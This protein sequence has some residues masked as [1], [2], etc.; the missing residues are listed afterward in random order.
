MY[1]KCHSKCIQC[2]S[3]DFAPRLPNGSLGPRLPNGSL[4]AKSHLI[5]KSKESDNLN[6]AK[7]LLS[8]TVVL[9]LDN[10]IQPYM[11]TTQTQISASHVSDENDSDAEDDS[12][13][14][15]SIC[16]TTEC[17]DGSITKFKQVINCENKPSPSTGQDT[18]ELKS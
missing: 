9:D 5:K 2:I 7:P 17:L 8:E 13:Q 4:G 14:N 18:D 16:K 15:I 1:I 11:E 6:T 3:N 12:Q 10:S